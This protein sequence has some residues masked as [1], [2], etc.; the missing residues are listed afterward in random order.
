MDDDAFDDLD[1]F[2]AFH[3]DSPFT[4]FRADRLPRFGLPHFCPRHLS[5]HS[6]HFGTSSSASFGSG[7]PFRPN[8]ASNPST[9]AGS[10]QTLTPRPAPPPRRLNLSSASRQPPPQTN[11]N[12]PPT[13]S[14]RNTS[15]TA[16]PLAWNHRATTTANCE[17]NSGDYY[18]DQVAARDFSSPSIPSQSPRRPGE[19]SNTATASN[20]PS[21]SGN[22]PLSS[23]SRPGQP[24]GRDEIPND[25][26]GPQRTKRERLSDDDESDSAIPPSSPFTSDMSSRRRSKRNTG[27]DA[28]VVETLGG[29]APATSSRRRRSGVQH[30]PHQSTDSLFGSPPAGRSSRGT[31]QQ[32]QSASASAKKRKRDEL[33][34]EAKKDDV[35]DESADDDVKIV[36]LVDVDKV[37]EAIL[38]KKPKNEVKLSAFQCVICMDDVVDLTVTHCGHL[39]C[40][41]CLHSSLHIDVSKKI[42]PICRQKI[43]A[44]PAS[45]KFSSKAKGYYNLE[46]KLMTRAQLGKQAAWS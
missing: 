23:D 42:C 34:T 4:S 26:F 27:P 13:F 14:T 41:G 40:S 29:P 33:D 1:L 6:L 32:E 28:D 12:S 19:T 17:P 5:S 7:N 39:F 20:F 35:F 36:D 44:K 18:L 8:A 45:G 21:L 37:P 16:T 24:R 43:D 2:S 31:T 46:L 11:T 3:G 25:L 30:T 15:N 9:G 22:T 10:R 38:P